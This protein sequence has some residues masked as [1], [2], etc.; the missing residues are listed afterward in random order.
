MVVQSTTENIK[1]K[2]K[3][4]EW[5][6]NSKKNFVEIIFYFLNAAE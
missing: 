3:Q 1:I 5:R 6:K 4:D 2:S